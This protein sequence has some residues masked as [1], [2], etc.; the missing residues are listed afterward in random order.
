VQGR[1]AVL[2][3]SAEIDSSS[4]EGVEGGNRVGPKALESEETMPKDVTTAVADAAVEG[5]TAGTGTGVRIVTTSDRGVTSDTEDVTAGGV[6]IG[7]VLLGAEAT[8]V[9]ATFPET[10]TDASGG[11]SASGGVMAA[12][13]GGTS[14]NGVVSI[15]IGAASNCA[16]SGPPG[17]AEGVGV[18]PRTGDVSIEVRDVTAVNEGG[19]TMA[20]PPGQF[21]R[22]TMATMDP[23]AKLK[24][25]ERR[26]RNQ[27]E[28]ALNKEERALKKEERKTKE[29]ASKNLAAANLAK[30]KVNIKVW[31]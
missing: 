19:M 2:S 27:E 14:G 29:L 3:V 6:T 23:A 13:G 28:R 4:V 8:G 10:T 30:V 9:V 15:K 21:Q 5:V 24:E 12:A 26:A 1:T 16:V 31:M 18:A 25:A 17:A 11:V 20:R 7:D 22:R